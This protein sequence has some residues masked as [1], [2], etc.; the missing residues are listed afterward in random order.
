MCVQDLEK[1]CEEIDHLGLSTDNHTSQFPSHQINLS[2]SFPMESICEDT[3]VSEDKY[4]NFI[5]ILRSGEWSDIGHRQYMED[6]H[7]CIPDLAR[8]FN[9]KLLGEEAISFYGVFDGHGGE[10]ASHFVRDNLPKIIVDDDS[11]PLELEKVVMRS[12]VETD[13]AFARSCAIESGL[14]SGTTALTAMIFGRSGTSARAHNWHFSLG[15]ILP[16][17]EDRLTNRLPLGLGYQ[18]FRIGFLSKDRSGNSESP[19][20]P[21]SFSGAKEQV[22]K[23]ASISLWS[24]LIA[25]A[26]RMQVLSGKKNFPE[27]TVGDSSCGFSLCSRGLLLYMD[28]SFDVSAGLVQDE[29]LIIGSDGVWDVFRSQNAVDFVRRRLQDH[30]DVKRCCKEMVEE[31]MKR[32]AD[33]N[34]TVVVVCFQAEPP[35]QVAVQRGRVRRSISAEGLL[36]LK[37]H[38]EG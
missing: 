7:I 25:F 13:A 23:P 36:N 34:L 27:L 26:E 30:N 12:F 4:N 33:D 17:V 21:G 38:L 28:R 1:V 5:P 37:F 32:G 22:S 35:P 14:S 6:T 20:S 11:F 8:N 18:I 19:S 24:S 2:T 15:R 3:V 29:F 16:G 9:N 31:A 10:G